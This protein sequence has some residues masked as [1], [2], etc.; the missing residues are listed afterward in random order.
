MRRHGSPLLLLL[1][2]LAALSGGAP[3]TLAREAPPPDAAQAP[4][5]QPAPEPPPQATPPAPAQPPAPTESPAAA[6]SAAAP[7][8]PQSGLFHRHR[9]RGQAWVAAANPLAVD[10]GL[11]ILARGGDAVDAAVAVQA[12]LGLVE[13][14]SSGVAGGAFL[15]YYDA[16]SGEVSA[17]DGREKAPAGATPDM[18]LDEHGK[19]LPFLAAV[20]SGRSTGVPGVIAMLYEAHSRYGHLRWRELFQPAIRAASDGFRVPERLAM[21]LGEGSPF[22]PT[23]EIRT[24]FSRPDGEVVQAGDLF[25]N[26]EYARTL[27]LIAH[28]GPRALYRGR[29]AEQI[30]AATHQQPLPGT[31]TLKDLSSYRPEWTDALC[32]PYRHYLV[33]VPPPPAGGVSLL[34]LLGILEKTDIVSRG[35]NDPQAWFLLGQASR[36]MYADRDRYV[37]DPHFISVPVERLLDPAYLRL[38]AQLIG[39]HAG[40]APPPGDVSLPHAPD[41]TTESAGTSHFVVVDADGNVVSMTTTVESVFGSGRTVGGFVLN[42]QLTDFSFVPSVDGRPVANAVRGGKRP[43]S[44]MSPII[45]LDRD[46]RFFAALGSPGGSAILEYNAKALVGLLAWKLTLKQAIELPNLIARGDNFSGELA[47]FN[48]EVLAGLR[49]RGMILRAGHAENSGLHGV[50]RL[51]D[52]TYQGAADSRREGEARMLA[53]AGRAARHALH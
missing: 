6:P 30:V 20:R 12:M 29:I 28:D 2:A 41:A 7:P 21:F 18:F 45:V 17:L 16:S 19:P 37:A 36:L 52:G 10:A 11:G 24:L 15:M 8:A 25:R 33:C 44:S 47:K 49:E 5:P 50:V 13:P 27:Q 1:A 22:P 35:P 32:R 4:L 23:N 46:N 14:Q 53:P 42:N 31:M 3:A 26:P 39:D 51:P 48:P 34:E 40:A 38:R 43:R 9:R